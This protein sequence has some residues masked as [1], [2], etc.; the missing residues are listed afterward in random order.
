MQYF[1]YDKDGNKQALLQNCT[2]IQWNPKYWETG[3]FEIHALRTDDNEDY[4]I[5]GNRV[6]CSDRNEI[7]FI[8]SVSKEGHTIEIH[9]KLNNLDRRINL[10]TATIKNIESSLLDLVTSNK[11]NL[12]INVG[13]AKGLEPTIKGGSETSYSNLVDSFEKY[14]Q[15]GSLGFREIAKDGQLNY[16]ELYQGSLKENAIFSDDL[17]NIKSQTYE[18]DLTD[19]VNYAYVLGEDTDTNRKQVIVDQ[20]TDGEEIRE[21]YVDARDLQST[22]EDDSG[23]EHAYTD[24]EYQALLIERGKQKL[25]E[26]NQNAYSFEF[27]LDPYSQIAE[28][29]VDYDLGDIVIVKSTDF[30][31]LAYARI[32]E[33]NFIEETNR[34]TQISI[35]TNIESK[36]VL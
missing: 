15:T 6:V 20:H 17:G 27:E 11:R 31:V 18:L 32:T 19:Y 34:N 23:T 33:L 36:E 14:C 9:G 25:A 2:S 8:N 21:L 12:D 16:L 26:N 5:E 35:T 7:G 24:A 10:G 1:I 13:S 30:K 28:L 29:G 3:T 22:Y 4:L